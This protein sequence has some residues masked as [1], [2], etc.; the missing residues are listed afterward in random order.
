M[1]LEYYT[2]RLKDAEP[3]KGLLHT[4]QHYDEIHSAI[5]HF[6]EKHP[7]KAIVAYKHEIKKGPMGATFKRKAMFGKSKPVTEAWGAPAAVGYLATKNKSAQVDQP[8]HSIRQGD[9]VKTGEGKTGQVTFVNGEDV[10]V[11]GTNP[12]YPKHKEIHQGSTLSKIN[13][14]TDGIQ[15][16]TKSFKTLMR[17]I[18]DKKSIKNLKVPSSSDRNP[19]GSMKPKEEPKKL[20]EAAQVTNK[21][22]VMCTVS[23]PNHTMV[24]KRKEKVQKRVKVTATGRDEAKAK[25]EAFYKKQGYKVHDVEYHSPVKEPTHVQQG[26]KVPRG[27]EMTSH[28]HVVKKTKGEGALGEAAE[29]DF[30]ETKH[31]HEANGDKYEVRGEKYPNLRRPRH[32][33][34][35]NGA[36]HSMA[37]TLMDARA[38]VNHIAST[39]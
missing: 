9:K 2:I 12:Y 13:E 15:E 36:Y 35:K 22:L 23:D 4:T 11:I 37:G 30:T 32:A 6:K 5:R 28:G 7:G 19:D 3:G 8:T 39:R 16:G 24:T 34:F 29:T 25:A 31:T 21:H 20:E 33:I 17:S 14:E 38:R 10:H 1:L 26:A 18:E 27:Y